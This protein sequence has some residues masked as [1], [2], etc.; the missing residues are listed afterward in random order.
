MA[1]VPEFA[2][3]Y[4]ICGFFCEGS[5]V[6][7]I[8]LTDSAARRLARQCAAPKPVITRCKLHAY[9]TAHAFTPLLNREIT[10]RA[11]RPRSEGE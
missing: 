2:G 7:V 11:K 9:H 10:S 4:G 6:E 1:N 8:H 5:V 3:M